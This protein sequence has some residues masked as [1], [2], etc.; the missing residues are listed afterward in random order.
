MTEIKTYTQ[1]RDDFCAQYKRNIVPAFLKFD[2]ERRLKLL[3]ANIVKILLF[4]A[5]VAFLYF[6]FIALKEEN[7]LYL[8]L[9]VFAIFSGISIYLFSSFFAKNIEFSIKKKVLPILCQL[10]GD[11]T[12]ID[13][14]GGYSNTAIFKRSLLVPDFDSSKVDDVFV[15]KVDKIKIDIIDLELLKKQTN[16]QIKVFGGSVIKLDLGKQI[17]GH[18]MKLF[19]SKLPTLTLSDGGFLKPIDI[20]T[21]SEKVVDKYITP[22]FIEILENIRRC[23]LAK[24]LVCIFYEN[25][26]LISLNSGKSL[27]ETASLSTSLNNSKKFFNVFERYLAIVKLIDYIKLDI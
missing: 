2:K 11:L 7:S 27:F 14:K 23:F 10:L 19:A 18:T 8:L 16:A 12:W 1:M 20:Y 9:F 4:I 22:K 26:I 3:I 17:L 21:N 15:G 25:Y 5:A 6:A 13:G 24:Q